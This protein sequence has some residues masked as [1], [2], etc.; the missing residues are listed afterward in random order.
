M[1]IL[2]AKLQNCVR[3]KFAQCVGMSKGIS[4]LIRLR[5]EFQGVVEQHERYLCNYFRILRLLLSCLLKQSK[6]AWLRTARTTR[7][8]KFTV[9]T[10]VLLVHVTGKWM[11]TPG[12]LRCVRY[13]STEFSFGSKA[14]KIKVHRVSEPGNET[15]Y[16]VLNTLEGPILIR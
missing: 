1:H 2:G 11:R 9:Q 12:F 6:S 4:E 10:L 13:E 7:T 16:D 14:I 8:G 3:V 15:I 5:S